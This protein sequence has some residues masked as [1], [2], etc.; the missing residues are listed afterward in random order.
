M[1]TI[2][3]ASRRQFLMAGT[4]VGS[5]IVIGGLA[6]STKAGEAAASAT[7]GTQASQDISPPEDLMREHGVLN[8]ILLIY[9]DSC[10]R[11]DGNKDLEPATLAGAA[12]IIRTFIEGYH[13][14]LEED[15]LFPR[16]ERAG[17]LVILVKT[18]RE[19]HEAGRHLTEQIVQLA[20]PAG[21]KDAEASRNLS[22]SLRQFV[23][24]YRPHE[25]REDTVLF[26][27][28]RSLM[29]AKEFDEMGDRF[30]DKEHQLFGEHGFEDIVAQ[31]AEMEKVLGIYDLSQ[32][33][34]KL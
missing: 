25:A 3:D 20:T 6:R 33:T 4:A 23:R 24:M 22:T 32:F 26:P 10:R 8:R 5:G 14:K 16:F 21:F 11:L 27:A 15:H 7:N 34:P 1:A 13:E 28:I 18:L 19:Q 31:V 17:K 12:K 9:E 29:T 30:E 2:S